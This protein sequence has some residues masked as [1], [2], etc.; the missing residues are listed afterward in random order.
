VRLGRGWQIL[1][2]SWNSGPIRPLFFTRVGPPAP[3]WLWYRLGVPIKEIFMALLKAARLRT[4]LLVSI[5][6]C[7]L[8]LTVGCQGG[9]PPA[10]AAPKAAS[11][12]AEPSAASGAAAKAAAPPT[13]DELVSVTCKQ[14][15]P[16]GGPAAYSLDH[17]KF[18][19]T[20]Q[21]LWT[22]KYGNNAAAPKMPLH[23]HVSPSQATWQIDAYRDEKGRHVFETHSFDRAKLQLE[24]PEDPFFGGNTTE[25]C[26]LDAIK[27]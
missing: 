25:Q 14:M 23:V 2:M 1:R 11:Q 12:T 5:C 10:S 15:V 4:H 6:C 3:D 8:S 21:L 9:N 13:G 16:S 22:D 7:L 26:T 18:N 24:L 20:K 19:M 17:L 27:K